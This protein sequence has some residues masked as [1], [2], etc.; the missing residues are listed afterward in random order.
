[1]LW[2]ALNFS[3]LRNSYISFLSYL[4]TIFTIT[5]LILFFIYN[6]LNVSLLLKTLQMSPFYLPLTPSTLL[7][8]PQAF[9][10]L[11]SLSKGYSY[12]HILVSFLV[13]LLLPPPSRIL[14]FKSTYFYHF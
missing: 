9:T 6:F 4:H 13:N 3:Y 7:P 2:Q 11:L 8:H 1:M 12:M 10:T 5:Y 14:F